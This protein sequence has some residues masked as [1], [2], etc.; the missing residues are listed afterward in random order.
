M[1][2]YQRLREPEHEHGTM[3]DERDGK[4]GSPFVILYMLGLSGKILRRNGVNRAMFSS[5]SRPA[6]PM[7]TRLNCSRLSSFGKLVASNDSTAS[8][9]ARAA[10]CRP[11]VFLS[12]QRRVVLV[13]SKAEN[14]E[15]DC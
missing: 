14:M 5:S 9:I 13:A 7:S 12:N 11:T 10:A 3:Y 15:N 2:K 4:R 6:A 1:P 8:I